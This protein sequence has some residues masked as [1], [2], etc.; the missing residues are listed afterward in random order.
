MAT[1][2][3]EA[4]CAVTYREVDSGGKHVGSQMYYLR[5]G[6]GEFAPGLG[7]S[8]GL[9]FAVFGAVE[10]FGIGNAVQVN[11]M[12]QVL[13][14]SFSVPVWLTGIVVAALVAFVI[15]GGIQRIGDVIGKLVPTMIVL[16]VGRSSSSSLT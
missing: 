9:L 13:N 11:F 4:V 10:A 3:A 5:N 6:V 1:K 8:L 15:L 16:Y 14:N 2:Y 7:K 12:A